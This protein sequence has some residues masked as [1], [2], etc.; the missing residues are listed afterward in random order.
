M[1]PNSQDLELIRT[2]Y[3]E[4]GERLRRFM[5][6][7]TTVIVLLVLA[8]V[9]AFGQVDM[10]QSDK[11]THHLEALTP[12]TG[13][14]VL[15]LNASPFQDF[16]LMS[17]LLVD[18]NTDPEASRI[19]SFSDTRWSEACNALVADEQIRK[20]LFQRL[21]T[22]RATLLNP[23]QDERATTDA[24]KP[25]VQGVS[26]EL[27]EACNLPPLAIPTPIFDL[28]DTGQKLAA[29]RIRELYRTAFSAEIG[30]LGIN[31]V[32]D[33]R[34]WFALIPL[35]VLISEIYLAIERKKLSLLAIAVGMASETERPADKS[36]KFYEQL[37]ISGQGTAFSRHP[38][39]L[40]G[41]FQYTLVILL[42][43]YLATAVFG[44]PFSFSD[45]IFP[46]LS[47]TIIL[48][49][50]ARRYYQRVAAALEFDLVAALGS[51]LTRAP[52]V[53]RGA[54]LATLYR[55]LSDSVGPK[56]QLSS[57]SSL[58]LLT[59]FMSVNFN[60]CSDTNPKAHQFLKD[61][62]RLESS[63][64]VDE[65]PFKPVGTW[66]LTST[67]AFDRFS[68][69]PFMTPALSY[70]IE[71]NQRL[72]WL[73]YAGVVGFGLIALPGTLMVVRWKGKASIRMLYV[74][75][76]FGGIS[77]A[78]FASDLAFY[79]LSPKLKLMVLA[80][81]IGASAYFLYRRRYD[82]NRL[83]VWEPGLP[84]FV[85]AYIFSGF[86]AVMLV[87]LPEK[88]S[89][90]EIATENMGL[91]FICLIGGMQLLTAGWLSLIRQLERS[92]QAHDATAFPSVDELAETP[93]VKKVAA[94]RS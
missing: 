8:Y 91:T 46:A 38:A 84:I 44:G 36:A 69:T 56:L 57:G 64:L 73:F 65:P 13:N 28:A 80:C 25:P 15:D 49:W 52:R 79:F 19:V 5:V 88:V 42:L 22:I 72:T 48:A 93:L 20:E 2:T 17:N 40:I 50:Y 89:F 60:F 76:L 21:L 71:G 75:A 66:W 86:W 18:F 53:R 7:R 29:S 12:M 51:P 39:Q 37:F 55:K 3:K 24:G 92:D 4:T 58:V 34:N 90:P 59:L 61:P 30:L 14:S 26:S 78:Y 47:T 63:D 10:E 94:T 43:G 83:S 32:V 1:K 33:L 16:F 6:V 31:A 54:S 67:L 82:G 35:V 77:S 9:R 87:L 70:V 27:E 45:V 68:R 62:G 74:G 81:C 85:S 23:V 11:L 41:V